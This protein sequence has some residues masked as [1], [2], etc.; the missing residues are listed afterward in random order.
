MRVT[1]GKGN[2]R[3]GSFNTVNDFGRY[4]A[5][6]GMMRIVRGESQI[7]SSRDIIFTP[8]IEVSGGNQ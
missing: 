3:L 7:K 8:P 2:K 6:E 5:T 1:L 4:V